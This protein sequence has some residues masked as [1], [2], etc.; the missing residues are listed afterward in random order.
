[1]IHIYTGDFMLPTDPGALIIYTG[2][3]LA[4]LAGIGRWLVLPTFRLARLTW[5]FLEDWNGQPA[6]HG[7]P[8]VPGV[9]DRIVAIEYQLHP[10]GGG[11][12]KD[13]VDRI[14]VKVDEQAT[15]AADVKSALES[16]QAKVRAELE[17][18]RTSTTEQF[19]QVW[20]TIAT[21]DIHKAADALEKA[22]DKVAR[23]PQEEA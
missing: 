22:A 11:S 12:M 2:A 13:A 19:N 15:T 17:E 18:H 20:Q 8:P 5:R 9:V 21:R 7:E 6:R 23:P 3:V 4:A 16:E 10:N 1:M 14:E